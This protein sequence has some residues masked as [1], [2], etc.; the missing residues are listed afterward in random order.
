[1]L[2]HWWDIIKTLLN[3]CRNTHP[4]HPH[5]NLLTEYILCVTLYHAITIWRACASGVKDGAINW[6]HQL[7]G[8]VFESI[9]AILSSIQSIQIHNKC[10]GVVSFSDHVMC[11]KNAKNIIFRIVQLYTIMMMACI[12]QNVCFPYNA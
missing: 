10:L 3:H 11:K 5:A 2:I 6:N 12:F 7:R 9:S 4:F 1:M 8:L